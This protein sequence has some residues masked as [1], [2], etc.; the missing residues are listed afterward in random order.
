MVTPALRIPRSQIFPSPL[1][2][3]NKAVLS[4]T[5]DNFLLPGRTVSRPLQIGDRVRSPFRQPGPPDFGGYVLAIVPGG[6]IVLW[7]S[8]V[9]T[10]DPIDELQPQSRRAMMMARAREPFP[11]TGDQSLESPFFETAVAIAPSDV[12]PSAPLSTAEQTDIRAAAQMGVS[13]P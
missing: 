13:Y 4:S 9:L 7:D 11:P 1:A 5:A 6:A 12:L 2:P 8:G 10:F 3:V